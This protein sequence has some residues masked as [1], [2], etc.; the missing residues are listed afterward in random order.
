[1]RVIDL[2]VGLHGSDTGGFAVELRSR[3]EDG[4]DQPRERGDAAI[5]LEVLDIEVDDELSAVAYGKTL[6]N[7]VFVGK[8]RDYFD[9]AVY[10]ARLA[11]TALRVRLFIGPGAEALHPLRWE[12]LHDPRSDRPVVQGEW[13]FFSRYLSSSNWRTVKLRP[14]DALKA[15][16][17]VANPS[18][19]T[20]YS[21]AQVDVAGE[22]KRARDALAGRGVTGG[23]NAAPIP[24]EEVTGPDTLLKMMDRLRDGY[25]ILY[26][27]CHGVFDPKT[28]DSTLVLE[29]AHG[30]LKRTAGGELVNRLSD[31]LNPPRLVVLASCQGAGREGDPRTADAQ[32]VLAAV[33]PRLA[34]AGLPAVLAMKGDVTM[35]TV[36]QFMPRFF[37]E[38]SRNGWV[39][40]AVAVARGAVSDRPDHWRPVLFSRIANGRIWS[41]PGTNP[42][43]GKAFDGWAG[44]VTAIRKGKCT[45]ILGPGLLDGLIG[46]T[47]EVARRWSDKED[48]AMSPHQRENLPQVTQFLAVMQGPA[49]PRDTFPQRLWSEIARRFRDLPAGGTIDDRL[50]QARQRRRD[51]H[52][53]DPHAELA[54]IPFPLYVVTTADD[55]MRQA[56]I[57]AG[58]EPQEEFCPWREREWEESDDEDKVPGSP[59][60]DDTK[61]NYI[62]KLENGDRPLVYH[63]YGQ[64]RYPRTLV[65]TEDDYFDY[66]IGVHA[67]PHAIRPGIKTAL[68]QRALLF[69]GFRMED[70]EFRVLFRSILAQ[71]GKKRL[72]EDYDHVAVQIEP[73]E[74]RNA[75]PAKARRYLGKYF[76]G[77]KIYIYWGGVDDFVRELR[78]RWAAQ[79]ADS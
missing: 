23:M 19:L 54:A 1:M 68:K 24:A 78:R 21:M 31:L 60:L 3:N 30:K 13:V 48:F 65:L 70:W 15:L 51:A 59:F 5:D 38:L 52:Q 17:V 58:K 47:R 36:E 27:V 40:R 50:K 41:D 49:Y 63:L 6:F 12:L 67:D 22:V 18:E 74:G 42:D 46:S 79:E 44:L 35:E 43:T 25:D 45:P 8:L 10:A 62:P 2:E 9:D 11:E 69:L 7:Q 57:E 55:Q 28:G 56:L 20:R 32:G 77:A 33:G 16:V 37:S 76:A 72:C 71:G 64:L 66:L 61:K 53:I 75:D 26:L 29:D 34:A 39:D 73:E 4:L 14:R